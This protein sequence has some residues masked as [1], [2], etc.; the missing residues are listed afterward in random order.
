MISVPKVVAAAAIVM[1]VGGVIT[2]FTL[3]EVNAPPTVGD[4]V[5]IE[6][7]ST[8]PPDDTTARNSQR[9]VDDRSEPQDDRDTHLDDDRDDDRDSGPSNQSGDGSGVVDDDDV[10]EVRPSPQTLDDRGDDD[11]DGGDDDD[12]DDGD[13]DGGDDQDDDGDDD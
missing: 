4:P 9:D 11:D 13:N 12:D 5:V 2:A 10:V 3:A 8:S 7:P 1:G 6:S